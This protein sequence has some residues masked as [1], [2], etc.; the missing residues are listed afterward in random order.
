MIE[1]KPDQS[2]FKKTYYQ[3]LNR[4][5]NSVPFIS[6]DR[7]G[8]SILNGEIDITLLNNSYHVTTDDVFDSSGKRPSFD[9]CVIL[10]KYL[11]I[12][13]DNYPQE[14]DWC[15]FRDFRD[16]NPLINYFKSNVGDAFIKEFSGKVDLLKKSCI[17]LGGISAQAQFNQDVSIQFNILP[18]IP[19][20]LLFNDEDEEFHATCSVLFERRAENYLDAECL[21]MLGR[22]LFKS[23]LSNTG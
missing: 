7:L 14:K 15:S 10:L 3:Y 4:V 21:A 22:F 19:V 6:A 20:L 11:L 1:E 23:V 2:V 17:L 5:F 16:S 18:R 13:R 8:V 9:V 12:D